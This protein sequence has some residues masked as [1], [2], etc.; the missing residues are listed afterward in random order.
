MFFKYITQEGI[1]HAN[2]WITAYF[3]PYGRLLH[4]HRVSVTATGTMGNYKQYIFLSG[5]NPP[6]PQNNVI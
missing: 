5:K 3:W 2:C 1:M 6:V 4:C